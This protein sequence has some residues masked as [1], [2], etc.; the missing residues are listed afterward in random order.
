MVV[1]WNVKC[2]YDK[3]GVDGFVGCIAWRRIGRDSDLLKA[4]SMWF[5]I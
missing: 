2:V 3:S 4:Y 5:T 1:H